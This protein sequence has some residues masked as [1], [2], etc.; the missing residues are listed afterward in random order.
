MNKL[1]LCLSVL[2]GA[3][4]LY[5]PSAD[6]KKFEI[7][8]CTDAAGQVVLQD[9][10]CPRVDPAKPK[11]PEQPP[12]SESRPANRTPSAAAQPPQ[13][14]VQPAPEVRRPENRPVSA[15]L[16]SFITRDG[17]L[18]GDVVGEFDIRMPARA[19]WRLEQKSFDGKLLQI[20]LHHSNGNPRERLQFQLDFVF[21]DDK[22]FNEAELRE[23]LSTVG[24]YMAVASVEQQMRIAPL[25]IS[26][27]LGVMATFTDAQ[28]AQ[29][30]RY[31][32]TDFLYTSKGFIYLNQWLV[33][34][35]LMS[36]DLQH[37][38][39]ASALEQLE[40]GLRIQRRVQ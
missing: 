17:T 22:R 36:N 1:T 2:V 24:R 5:T 11:P 16:R 34:F 9:R 33:N 39:Y 27:G 40:T 28:L 15:P 8:R 35:T 26:R 37:S 14:G 25:K 21:V 23:L 10:P 38:H 13:A 19:G 18:V 7:H 29:A 30:S 20:K 32:G 12:Q 31:S 4:G 6:A 3:S